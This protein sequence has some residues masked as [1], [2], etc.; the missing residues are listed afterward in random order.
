V[1]EV[2]RHK[3]WLGVCALA[4]LAAGC[5]RTIEIAETD[6]QQDTVPEPPA[7]PIPEPEPTA[8][9]LA[10]LRTAELA[11]ARIT[12]AAT[13]DIMLGTDYPESRLAEDNGQSLLNE[14]AP[15][16][17]SAD[18]AFGNLEGVLMDGGEPVKTCKDPS[19]CYLFR[20]PAHHAEY[21]A[22]AGFTVM[23]LA[24]NHARDF[25]EQGRTASMAALDTAGIRH[26]GRSGDI[27][28]WPNGKI[29]VALIAF[30]PFTNS[31]PM[32][33]L[34]AARSEVKLLSAAFDL[35]IVSFH[36]G[37]EGQDAAHVPF[38]SETYFGEDRGNV[39]EFSRTMIDNGA[40]LVIGHGPHVPRAAE[41]YNGR[42]IAYSLGNFATYYGISISE[43]KGLAP[44]LIATIDGNG[45]FISGEIVSAIQIRPYGPRLDKQHRAY[46]RIWELTEQDFGGGGIRFQNGGSFFPAIESDTLCQQY[47]EQTNPPAQ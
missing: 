39:V 24:N 31:Y 2:N 42:L 12:V 41:I 20:S 29:R 44:I 13:G 17:S 18:I 36:G 45:Q 6:T 40:D 10:A 11:C 27:A 37:A 7:E 9:Q 5:A 33:D 32:L 43:D 14:V 25:G 26:S 3:Y 46:E 38:A 22:D 28:T 16:I 4:L 23:S 8:E 47:P 34:D 21:L 1:S 19:A 30:A 15:V 35:V